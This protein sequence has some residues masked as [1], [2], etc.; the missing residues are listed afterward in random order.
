MK[1]LLSYIVT[2]LVTK[3]EAVVIDEQTQD[4]NVDLLLTVDPEDMGLIIGKGGQ[5]IR[6]IRK[7]LT[8]RAIAENVRVNLQ[9]SEPEGSPSTSKGPADAGNID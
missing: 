9:L 5:T 1:D 4:G 2:S 3:P 7:L 6:S 8:V